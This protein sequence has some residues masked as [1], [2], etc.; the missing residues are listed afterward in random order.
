MSINWDEE[1]SGLFWS[2]DHLKNTDMENDAS[3]ITFP[4]S[5]KIYSWTDVDPLE[6]PKDIYFDAY[7]DSIKK[8]DYP[9]N[10]EGWPIM[11]DRMINTLL[12]VGD[13][14]HRK[15]PVIMLDDTVLSE[16]RY[17]AD[18]VTLKDGVAM[19]G[20]SAIQLTNHLDI[21][22]R[23]KSVYQ[24]HP[25][26]PSIVARV[27]K[28]EL[29][30]MPDELPPIFRLS[31]NSWPLLITRKAREALEES[32]IRGVDFTPLYRALV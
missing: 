30:V 6:I 2:L 9:S 20:Y 22:D 23:E 27:K 24:K 21:F 19:D 7:F 13:F 17:V 1:I 12:S 15:I 14:P 11:S 31:V 5:E 32:G 26:N 16:N 8:I 25:I 18:G 4:G 29:T 28:L 10:N 3:L